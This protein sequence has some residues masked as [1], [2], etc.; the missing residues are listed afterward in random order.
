VVRPCAGWKDFSGAANE[1][2]AANSIQSGGESCEN[3]KGEIMPHETEPP[4][5]VLSLSLRK[6][7]DSPFCWQSKAA[8]RLIRESLDKERTVASGIAVYVALT[9]IAS[10]QQSETFITTEA[11]VAM[12]AGVSVKTA[13]DRIKD[14]VVIGL[15]KVSTAK[16][17]APSTFTLLSV[18][19]PLPNDKQPL[20]NVR[21][22]TKNTPLPTSEES[23]EESN[24]KNQKKARFKTESVDVSKI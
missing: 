9:E 19:K 20:L 23:N 2:C 12:K 5:H 7:S 17:K 13:S 1:P 21:Q 10:D 24:E 16:L 8:L 14:L 6:A 11:W 22:R 4:N 15:V 3:G 18:R